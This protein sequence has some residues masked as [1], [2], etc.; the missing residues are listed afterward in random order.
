M[1]GKG[2]RRGAADETTVLQQ[3]P[4]SSPVSRAHPYPDTSNAAP[5]AA[6]GG[7]HSPGAPSPSALQAAP[8]T[9]VAR[10]RRHGRH[11]TFPVIV[12]LAIA[13]AS[14]YFIGTFPEAW[15][16][17]VAALGAVLLAVLLGI[18]PILSWLSRRAVVTTRRVIVHHGFFV[19]HRS[20]VSLARVREVRS[21]QNPVQRLFGSGDIDLYVG[22]EPTRIHDAPAAKDLHAAVQELSEKSYDEQMRANPFGF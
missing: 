13:V 11:L 17:L 18:A 20:E 19:R 8:E 12:L 15:M 2:A 10:V 5:A 14:G 3:A 1:W 16:N 4:E 22:A 21:K 7:A 9:I 6:F